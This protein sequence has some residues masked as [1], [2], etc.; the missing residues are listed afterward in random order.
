MLENK[1]E[2]MRFVYVDARRLL[3]VS[4]W[5]KEWE[6]KKLTWFDDSLQE[7]EA[8][9]RDQHANQHAVRHRPNSNCYTCFIV[10]TQ[11]IHK[12][13]RKPICMAELECT[14]QDS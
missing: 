9:N 5:L 13:Y 4:P 11:R 2:I 7:M 1:D 14:L 3:D 12:R 6:I 10:S 8:E